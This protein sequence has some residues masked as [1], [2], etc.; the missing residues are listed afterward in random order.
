MVIQV[1]TSPL[2][3]TLSVKSFRYF[4]S[5]S[6]AEFAQAESNFHT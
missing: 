4:P 2:S 3:S 6:S 5:F 1:I